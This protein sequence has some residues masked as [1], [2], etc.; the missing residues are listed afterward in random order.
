MGEDTAVGS[1]AD[2]SEV[3]EE[4]RSLPS[5]L[6]L[7]EQVSGPGDPGHVVVVCEVD[8]DADEGVGHGLLPSLIQDAGESWTALAMVSAAVARCRVSMPRR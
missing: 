6:C 3:I 2:A 7:L 5:L 8:W 1:G 4:Y